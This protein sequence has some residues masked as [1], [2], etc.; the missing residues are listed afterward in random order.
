[1]TIRA[2]LLR[3]GGFDRV[4][5]DGM[6]ELVILFLVFEIERE[7]EVKRERERVQEGRRSKRQMFDVVINDFV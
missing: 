4:E 2:Y 1:M 7:R 3:F 6:C 5:E